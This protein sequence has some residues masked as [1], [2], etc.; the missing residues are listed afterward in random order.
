M[1][2]P[3]FLVDAAITASP[4]AML[5]AALDPKTSP[6]DYI[7]VG[8]GAGGGP[9][10]A[11]L[12]LGDKRVLLIEAGGDPAKAKSVDYP[13]AEP[14]EVHDIPCYHGASTEDQ[15]MSWQYS[16][17]HYEDDARQRK[18]RKY[19][20]TRDATNPAFNPDDGAGFWDGVNREDWHICEMAQAGVRSRAYRPGPYSRRESLSAAFDRYYRDA[21]GE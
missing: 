21:M 5:K 15:E 1:S 6:F 14:G 3:K 16:V 8:S 18:D 11:R 4:E 2:N 13:E 7:I 19:D 20:A 9:L 12:A 10:A 17:R